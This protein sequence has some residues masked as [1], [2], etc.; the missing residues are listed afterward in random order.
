MRDYDED[1]EK[2]IEYA[3]KLYEDSTGTSIIRLYF[4]DSK[5]IQ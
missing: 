1:Y 2:F 4:I 5:K 3:G